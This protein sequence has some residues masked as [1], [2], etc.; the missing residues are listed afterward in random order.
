MGQTIIYIDPSR[1][2]EQ[3]KKVFRLEDCSPNVLK[4]IP[5]FK[6]KA[7]QAIIKLSPLVDINYCLTHIEYLTDVHIVTVNNEVKELL[8]VLDFY[9]KETKQSIHVVNLNTDQETICFTTDALNLQQEYSKVQAYLYE[10]HPGLMKSGAFGWLCKTYNLK[11]IAQ[12][13][14]LFTSNTEIRFPGRVFR[15]ESVIQPNKKSIL[16]AIDGRKA[17]VACRN[18]PL[19]PEQVKKK[20]G[21]IDGSN[22]YVFFTTTFEDRKI[23]IVC[24]K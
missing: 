20:Y 10:P 5:L 23:V 8:L 13:S 7:K 12:H 2:N 6:A 9:P 3:A 21:M 15:V 17:I 22:F 1:R 18:Y 4:H 11:A 19:K 24:K 14:H 16:K